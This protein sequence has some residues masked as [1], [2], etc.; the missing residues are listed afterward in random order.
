TVEQPT[1]EVDI[2]VEGN[3]V[4]PAVAGHFTFPQ[5]EGCAG[6][7][8]YYTSEVDYPEPY[9]DKPT[10]LIAVSAVPHEG[11][12]LVRWKG[13]GPVFDEDGNLRTDVALDASDEEPERW[14]RDETIYVK[15][16]DSPVEDGGVD[17]EDLEPEDRELEAEM[18]R[19]TVLL[20]QGYDIEKPLVGFA[21]RSLWS[22][23]YGREKIDHTGGPSEADATQEL[24]DKIAENRFDIFVVNAHGHSDISNFFVV[25]SEIDLPDLPWDPPLVEMIPPEDCVYP[26]EIALRNTRRYKLFYG[27][28]CGL[29]KGDDGARW[30]EAF[31][32]VGRGLD[33]D[34]E[35]PAEACITWDETVMAMLNYAFDKAFWE[36]LIAEN[37]A[38][39]KD[40]ALDAFRAARDRASSSYFWNNPLSGIIARPKLLG[41]TSLKRLRFGLELP[42]PDFEIPEYP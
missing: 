28:S 31:G 14:V 38:D 12:D 32:N 5:P 33:G 16:L 36:S 24:M 41:D 1:L 42:I 9:F 15:C 30:R 39:R 26:D 40:T 10:E 25:C 19:P 13:T 17:V 18:A 20:V 6:A 29:G 21:E 7:R 37:P 2:E 4:P 22:L 11:F 35:G 27:S 34:A 3:L 8:K 23:R